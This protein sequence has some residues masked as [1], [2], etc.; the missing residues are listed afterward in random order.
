MR[1]RERLS[2]ARERVA[3]AAPFGLE[4]GEPSLELR[5]HVVERS[6]ELREL[7]PPPNR[8]ALLQVA[9]RD[10]A[11]SRGEPAQVPDDRPPLQVRDDA[12]ERQAHEQPGEEPVACACG[13][14]I[15]HGLPG[16]DGKPRR[17]HSRQRRRGE[18][19]ITR[20]ADPD[21]RALPGRNRDTPT[22]RRHRGQDPRP[23]EQDE[24]VAGVEP[25]AAPET[26]DEPGV[27]RDRRHDL[28]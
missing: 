18:R 16:Q 5:S 14:G 27:E 24:N 10:S 15:D 20:A 19:A 1:R 13:G 2:E 11:G 8:D 6:T 23:L 7:V 4:L 26:R 25:C 28:A 9:M 17:R 3:H 22:E 12:D 21:R